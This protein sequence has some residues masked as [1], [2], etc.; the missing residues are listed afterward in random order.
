MPPFLHVTPAHRLAV[1]VVGVVVVVVAGFVVVLVVVVVMVAVV[2]VVLHVAPGSGASANDTPMNI[3]PILVRNSSHFQ[4]KTLC[5]EF[6][7][8][9]D[10]LMLIQ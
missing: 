4:K 2:V 8:Y 7:D 10:P 3:P 1:V 6:V 9:I 5:A